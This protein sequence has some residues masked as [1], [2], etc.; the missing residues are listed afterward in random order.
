MIYKKEANFPYPVLSSSIANYEE[1]EF[2]IAVSFNEENDSYRFNV[3]HVMSSKFIEKLLV[4]DKAQYILNMQTKDTKFFPLKHDDLVVEIP[5]NRM[6]LSNRTSIQLHIVAKESISFAENDELNPF[7]DQ[8]KGAIYVKKNSMLA[9]S[10][11]VTF[12]GAMKKPFNIFEKKLDKD[13]KS[14][15]KIEVGTESIIIHYR[16]EEFLFTAIHNSKALMNPYFYT[17]LRA[18]LERFILNYAEDETVLLDELSEPEDLLDY[19]LFHLMKAKSV[20]ELTREN[21]DEVVGKITKNIISD[22]V[23]AVKGLIQNED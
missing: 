23:R 14:E 17:G 11:V 9:Y 4:E 12:E 2:N 15:I 7:Y 20:D 18:A 22:Y 5:K 3:E 13:L 19:K 10:N 21:L 8:M 16:D 1:S 6:S